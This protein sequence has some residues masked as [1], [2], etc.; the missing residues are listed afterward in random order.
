MSEK[1]VIKNKAVALHKIF[2]HCV[3]KDEDRGFFK[4]LL[5][6][7]KGSGKLTYHLSFASLSTLPTKPLAPQAANEP[8]DFSSLVKGKTD[9]DAELDEFTM[10][11]LLSLADHHQEPEEQKIAHGID[12]LDKIFNISSTQKVSTYISHGQGVFKNQGE[13]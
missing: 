8:Y 7:Q 10:T 6:Y 1:F 12:L 13:A 2:E 11:T 4:E 9:M 5:E 3:I